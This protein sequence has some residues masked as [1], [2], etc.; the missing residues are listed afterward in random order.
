MLTWQKYDVAVDIWSAGCIFAE[1]LEGKPLFP[2]KDRESI[3]EP[4]YVIPASPILISGSRHLRASVLVGRLQT[5]TSFRLS[6]SFLEPHPR[7]SSRPSRARTSVFLARILHSRLPLLQTLRFVQSLPKR[8]RVPFSEKL[9]CH[10]PVGAFPHTCIC[11][12]VTCF[13][14]RSRVLTSIFTQRSIF[15][16]R[17]S[18]SI[19]ESVSTRPNPSHTNTS[20]RTTTRRTSRRRRKCLIGVSTMPIFLLIPGRS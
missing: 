7:M 11:I 9:H 2:G 12:F 13:W 8:E 20:P 3:F 5:C 16:R 17:C 4:S 10:D 14:Y 15:S 6:L 19:R 18:C 1:M